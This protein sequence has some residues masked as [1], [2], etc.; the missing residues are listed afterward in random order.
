VTLKSDPIK[1]V[2]KIVVFFDICSS[3]AILEDLVRTENQKLWRD[4]ILGL[5]N[6]LCIKQS[7]VGFEL[8]KFQG[9][10]WILFFDPC[11][12]GF[13]IFQ[14][15]EKLSYKFV[16]IYRRN[17]KDVLTVRIPVIGL[18]FGMDI[19]SCIRFKM[20]RKTE[21][22]GRP[23]NIASRLRDA[24]GQRGGTP[25]NKV[26]LSKNLY[27]TFDDKEKIEKEY[28]VWGVKRK[29]KNISGGEEYHC[30][31]VKLQ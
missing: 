3:T 4:L 7:S 13:D 2:K 20:N 31:K 9:D 25:E 21:Y 12:E 16:S 6:Y 26:L 22:M 15:C 17:I 29:L 30:V 19:G 24:I 5:K 23:L 11:S 1:V 18:T 27:A 14:F 8:Y 10:G 28:K